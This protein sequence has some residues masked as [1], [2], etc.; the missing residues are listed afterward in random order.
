MK[1]RRTVVVPRELF[2]FIEVNLTP[3]TRFCDEGLMRLGYENLVW[4]GADRNVLILVDEE[5]SS[6]DK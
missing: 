4:E 3:A 6:F 2:Q 1:P 5:L